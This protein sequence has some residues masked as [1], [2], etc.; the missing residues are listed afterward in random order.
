VIG[1]SYPAFRAITAFITVG[2]Q[3]SLFMWKRRL[4]PLII[5]QWIADL[6]PGI[7]AL[8]FVH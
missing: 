4:L 5:T 1:G 3:T 2:I 6:S 8:V 7:S